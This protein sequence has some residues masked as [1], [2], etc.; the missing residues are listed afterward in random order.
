MVIIITFFGSP[1][2][3]ENIDL[4]AIWAVVGGSGITLTIRLSMLAKGNSAVA[5]TE[6]GKTS[7]EKYRNY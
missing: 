4:L 2:F 6:E 5:T 1:T 7:H 3:Y